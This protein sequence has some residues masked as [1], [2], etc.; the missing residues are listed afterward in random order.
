ME[1]STGFLL[2][3]EVFQTGWL[4]NQLQVRLVALEPT[5]LI[6]IYEAFP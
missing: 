1:E 4:N 3:E 5:A 2:K 6:Q